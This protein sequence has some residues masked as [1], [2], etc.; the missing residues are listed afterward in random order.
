VFYVKRYTIAVLKI[1]ASRFSVSPSAFH[2][3]TKT[4]PVRSCR[5]IPNIPDVERLQDQLLWMRL[6][7]PQMHDKHLLSSSF[8]DYPFMIETSDAKMR[9][10]APTYLA[11]SDA[12]SRE[13]GSRCRRNQCNQRNQSISATTQVS[14]HVEHSSPNGLI[15]VMALITLITLITH[16]KVLQHT[17]PRHRNP[18]SSIGRYIY[19]VSISG[20]RSAR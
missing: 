7:H 13:R 14:D 5:T 2:C 15:A 12:K 20:R 19:T 17:V 3:G 9:C 1:Q 4:T 16:M 10:I 6:S 11:G 8:L 18:I